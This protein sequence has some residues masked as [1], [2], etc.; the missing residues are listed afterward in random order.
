M[1]A[2]RAPKFLW[3][4]EV[5]WRSPFLALLTGHLPFSVAACRPVQEV[6][7]GDADN[8][9]EVPVEVG[10]TLV[11][12]LDSN[13]TTGYTREIVE[14]DERVLKETKH[15]YKAE[16]RVS[17]GSSGK[18]IWRFLAQSPGRTSLAYRLHA[19]RTCSRAGVSAS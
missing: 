11:L 1:F 18:E 13:A 8:G 17:V 9:A 19:R 12:S 10:Q 7:I 16:E 6:R 2:A 14:L 4:N 5:N 3:R 15:E